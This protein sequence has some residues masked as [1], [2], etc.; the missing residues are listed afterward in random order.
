[1]GKGADVKA[2]RKECFSR[3]SLTLAV[4]G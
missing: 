3:R 4:S 2:S 1:M